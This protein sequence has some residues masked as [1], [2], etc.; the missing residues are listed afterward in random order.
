MGEKMIT[1][2]N[3]NLLLHLFSPFLI[4]I[5]TSVFI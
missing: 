1:E 2:L 4:Y 5:F 3:V